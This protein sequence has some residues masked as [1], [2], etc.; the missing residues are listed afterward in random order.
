MPISDL[1]HYVGVV[2]PVIIAIVGVFWWALRQYRRLRRRIK[3]LEDRHAALKA[4]EAAYKQQAV[5]AKERA[6]DLE[7]QLE[8]LK[9]QLLQE[10]ERAKQAEADAAQLSAQV[11]QVIKQDER[12]WE[13]PVTGPSFQP[14]DIRKAPIIAVLNLKGGVGKPTLT[15]NLAGLLAQQGRKVL[16]IDADYQRNLSML[17]VSDN[18]RKM[19]HLEQRTLQHFLS[20]RNSLLA[21][22]HQV[23]GL[24]GCRVVTNSDT[25]KPPL[26][27]SNST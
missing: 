16:V 25:V 9:E 23:S 2:G 19:L 8:E 5:R 17:L 14:L 4:S 6:G 20:G 7:A 11:E 15:A 10:S 22:A 1:I 24:S 3:A 26:P 27:N 12:V 18:D 13:R 21:V